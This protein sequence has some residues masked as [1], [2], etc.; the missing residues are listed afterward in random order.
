MKRLAFVLLLVACSKKAAED[1][2]PTCAEVT[3][4]V[5]EVARIAYPGHGDMGASGNRQSQIDA[6][7]ARKMPVAER[8]CMIAAKSMEA[9]AQCRRPAMS[10]EGSAA[11]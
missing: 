11:K 7:E 6:C 1:K 5:L 8:R 9:L 4:H 10:T 2:G 3:D